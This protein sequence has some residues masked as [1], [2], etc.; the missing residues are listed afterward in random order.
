MEAVKAILQGLDVLLV[1]PTGGG[2]SLTYQL[3]AL[4]SPSGFAVVISP[5]IALAKDQVEDCLDRDIDAALWNSE[6]DEVVKTRLVQDISCSEPATKVL[7][8]TPESLAMP[9]LLDALKE[10]AAAGCLTLFGVDEAHC[11]SQ[12]G[13]DFRPAYLALAS[14]RSNFPDVPILALTR[15][16]TQRDWTQ[17]ATNVVVATVAFGMGI[18]KADV[19]WV[20]HWDAPG[21]LEALYQESGRAGRDGLPSRSIVYVSHAELQQMRSLERGERR[22]SSPPPAY[23][24]G[25]ALP[26]RRFVSGL[27]RKGFKPPLKR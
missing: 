5:L 26:P 2:K 19:R 25:T 16:R 20:V 11:V 23:V 27:R 17:G 21:S 9:R 18:D 6:T 3:P 14:L 15:L 12:W 10:A 24:Q 1:L 4:T 8:T 13:H 7:Y 22:G